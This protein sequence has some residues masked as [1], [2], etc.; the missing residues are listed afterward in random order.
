ML[1]TIKK[2][3]F[4]LGLGDGLV[5]PTLVP[6]VPKCPSAEPLSYPAPKLDVLAKYGFAMK[7]EIEPHEW[8]SGKI[9]RIIYGD[10]KPEKN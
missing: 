9:L 2:R 1:V 10:K 5:T 6:N 7:L 4:D 8:E 3:N